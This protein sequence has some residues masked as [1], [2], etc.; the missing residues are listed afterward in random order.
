MQ[1]HEVKKCPRCGQT[2]ECRS[3][4]ILKCQ[5]FGISINDTLQKHIAQHYD[6][7]LCRN[8]LAEARSA[9]TANDFKKSSWSMTTIIK[10][11]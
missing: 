1:K 7:C 8:C 5:C 3:G 4:D 11:R 9:K 2:F 6:E 10:N